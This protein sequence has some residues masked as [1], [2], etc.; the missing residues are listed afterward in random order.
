MKDN[1]FLP[2]NLQPRQVTVGGWRQELTAVG[3][4]LMRRKKAHSISQN[5]LVV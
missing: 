3:L 4:I 5:D 1:I 2:K